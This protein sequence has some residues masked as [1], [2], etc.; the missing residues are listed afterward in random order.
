[1]VHSPGAPRTRDGIH[2]NGEF[3]KPTH[4]CDVCHTRTP[5]G[6]TVA[7]RTLHRDARELYLP[8]IGIFELFASYF[9]VSN[10]TVR[11]PSPKL[12]LQGSVSGFGEADG[13]SWK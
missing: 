9:A 6:A 4:T 12:S 7:V 3:W 8:I 11:A 10:G 2:S 1:M 13:S 5:P